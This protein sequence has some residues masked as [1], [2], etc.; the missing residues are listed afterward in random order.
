[1]PKDNIRRRIVTFDT[2]KQDLLFLFIRQ[3]NP[4]NDAVKDCYGN[5]LQL[6]LCCKYNC[7]FKL[8]CLIKNI[9]HTLSPKLYLN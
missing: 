3:Q 2:E 8:C 6:V 4:W 1:M 9:E 7:F 5:S